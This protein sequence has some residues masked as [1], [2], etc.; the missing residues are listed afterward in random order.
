MFTRL[1]LGSTQNADKHNTTL[2]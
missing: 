2:L 1:K